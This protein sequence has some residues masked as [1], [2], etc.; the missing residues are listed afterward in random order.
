MSWFETIK[1][2]GIFIPKLHVLV[3]R[4]FIGPF[5]TGFAIVLFILVIQF[6]APYLEDIVGKNLPRDVIWQVFFYP[7]IMLVTL[8]LPLA[9][10]LSSLMTLGNMGE[11]YELAAIKSAG[12][13]VWKIVKPMAAVT[14]LVV[15]FSM[16]F[17]FYIVPKANMKFF[18]LL[19]DVTRVKPSFIIRPGHFYRGIDG[20]V[21]H[22]ADKN[23]DRNL[24]Y[25]I[26]IYDHSDK[27]RKGN[28]KI[29][30]ADSA[31]MLGSVEGNFITM[32]LFSG[33]SHEEYPEKR[34]KSN[35]FQYGRYYFDTLNFHFQLS[36]F[37]MDPENDRVGLS[38][39]HYMKNIHQLA[40]AVDSVN[41]K[42]LAVRDKLPGYM[43][44]VFKMDSSF[45]ETQTIDTMPRAPGN[46]VNTFPN[47]MHAQIL[48]RAVNNARTAKNYVK[49]TRDKMEDERK[50]MLRYRIEYATRWMLP[51]SVIAFL[52]IGAPLGSIIRKGGIAIP[53]I[54]SIF[55]F[56]LFY[57]LMIQGKKFAQ[58]DILPAWIGVMLPCIVLYPVGILLVYQAATDSALLDLALWRDKLRV[59]VV[60]TLRKW[61]VMKPAEE[62]E[63]KY[64]ED[65][66]PIEE[67]D[68]DN[69]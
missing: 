24:L 22:C 29:V 6:V 69:G 42:R 8:A 39:H 13:S 45:L 49:F 46:V 66:F 40:A 65:G 30:A 31:R 59:F 18:S 47:T 2:R 56:I 20:Y 32:Q 34:G 19:F 7:S 53:A 15:A 37:E 1:K 25:G 51:V 35:K 33:V 50:K 38:P 63:T 36:G 27:K 62:S 58:D 57:I 28:Y 3:I 41:D 11:K 54:I 16:Y 4:A 61:K 10:L 55:F 17:S 21:I 48:G 12:I 64:D 9:V 23:D 60:G 43:K 44:P 26:K 5:F 68:E 14:L 52:L 67:I